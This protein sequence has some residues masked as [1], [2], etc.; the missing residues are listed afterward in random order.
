M[1]SPST[2]FVLAAGIAM[3]I[4]VETTSIA[5]GTIVATAAATQI[6]RHTFGGHLS[7]NS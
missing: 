4:V 6:A 3:Q 7:S 5:T 2:C 1:S